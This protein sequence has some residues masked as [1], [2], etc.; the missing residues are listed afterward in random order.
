MSTVLGI[1]K[2]M[3]KAKD[4][5]KKNHQIAAA[6]IVYLIVFTAIGMLF[7]AMWKHYWDDKIFFIISHV[8]FISIIAL[9]LVELINKKSGESGSEYKIEYK[10]FSQVVIILIVMVAGVYRLP[11]W[12]KGGGSGDTGTG[13]SYVQV[14]AMQSEK[15]SV[16]LVKK[17]PDLM[18]FKVIAP[19]GN[20]RIAIDVPCGF[21]SWKADWDEEYGTINQ[22]R[23]YEVRLNEN[24]SLIKKEGRLPDGKIEYADFDTPAWKIEFISLFSKK[25]ST[26]NQKRLAYLPVYLEVSLMK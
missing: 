9:E 16:T 13:S 6:T 11:D 18:K 1:E 10:R 26:G 3:E 23:L 4:A 19:A 12:E 5:I 20:E 17:T 21:S 22:Y 25:S 24:D 2:T 8:C 14:Q 15:G 7:P